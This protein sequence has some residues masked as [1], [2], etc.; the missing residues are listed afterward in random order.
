MSQPVNPVLIRGVRRYGAGEQ[1]DVL[2]DDGQ[3]ENV[4]AQNKRAKLI[5]D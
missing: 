2:V 1:V 5:R 4:A 3:I